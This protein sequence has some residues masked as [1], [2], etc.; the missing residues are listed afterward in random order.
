MMNVDVKEMFFSECVHDYM[1][2]FSRGL[3]V[4]PNVKLHQA[5]LPLSCQTNIDCFSFKKA[6]FLELQMQHSSLIVTTL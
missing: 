5:R 2:E 3:E 1:N 4:Y 6:Y